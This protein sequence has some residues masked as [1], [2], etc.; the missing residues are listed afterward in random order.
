V[1]HVLDVRDGRVQSLD[2]DPHQLGLE[3]ADL[4]AIRGGAPEDN[5]RI[6]RETFDGKKGAV[7]DI[8]LLNAAA[9]LVVAGVSANMREG[10]ARASESIDS[11]AARDTLD[12][13][14][15]VSSTVAR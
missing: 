11:G 8:V 13:L 3:P 14:V 15:R 10:V 7:R 6:V 9:G 4:S 1:N 5:A 12:A 2:V